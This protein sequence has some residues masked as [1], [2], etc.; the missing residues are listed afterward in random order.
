MG[1]SQKF[2]EKIVNKIS[3]IQKDKEEVEKTRLKEEIEKEEKERKDKL[4]YELNIYIYSNSGNNSSIST[5]ISNYNT[6]IFDWKLKNNETNFSKDCSDR[7][8]RA[9]KKDFREKAFKNVLIIPINS[10]S[11]FQNILGQGDDKNVL[12]HFDKNLIV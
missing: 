1:N 12:L 9:F 10:I 11:D 3:I 8:I 6:D 2:E 7:F 4:K 5:I